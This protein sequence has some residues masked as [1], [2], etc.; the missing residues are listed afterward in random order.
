M[1]RRAF[2]CGAAAIPVWSYARWVEPFHLQLNQHQFQ[3]APLPALRLV[4]LSDL[5]AC[6]YVPNS[7]IEATIELAVRQKPDLICVTGD[8]ITGYGE[9]DAA[10]YSKALKRL[11][12]AAP[13]FATLG[14][15][16]GAT[17]SRKHGGQPDS[18]VVRG[19]LADAGI[20]G[21]HNDRADIT[22]AGRRV[23]VV[24]L[25]DLG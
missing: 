15:H 16:D 7:L 14:N 6:S 22:V 21:L 23:E 3:I 18:M 2:L 11:T 24:G 1:M 10:W 9:F 8:F 5:H 12:G 20:R 13:V 17:W 4:H 25:G 19:I